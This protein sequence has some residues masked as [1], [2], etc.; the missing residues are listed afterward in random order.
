MSSFR[1]RLAAIHP[2]RTKD[3]MALGGGASDDLIT[4]SV[5]LDDRFDKAGTLVFAGA[6]GVGEE[7]EPRE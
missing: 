4:P 7:R 6:V 3:G 5:A 1:E 2:L